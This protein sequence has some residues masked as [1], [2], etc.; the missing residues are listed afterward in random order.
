MT[1]TTTQHSQA[2]P[3]PADSATGPAR[4]DPAPPPPGQRRR[5]GRRRGGT[6]TFTPVV[7][8][9]RPDREIRWIGKV[10]P[11]WIF[12]GEHTLLIEPLGA[13]RVRFT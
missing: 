2:A 8:A 11:G 3:E 5:H 13:G 9:V 12:D 4:P 10:G 7:L 6:T 1:T